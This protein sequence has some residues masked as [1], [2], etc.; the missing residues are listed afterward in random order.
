MGVVCKSY[1]KESSYDDIEDIEI[2]YS[3]L[4]SQ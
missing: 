4:N 3:Q 1:Q 2:K